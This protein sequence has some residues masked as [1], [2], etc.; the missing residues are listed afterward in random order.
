[1]TRGHWHGKQATRN[2]WY[3]PLEEQEAVDMAVVYTLNRPDLF[4]NTIGA[5]DLLPKTLDAASHFRPQPQ[6]ELDAKMAA[7]L[8]TPM[9]E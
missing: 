8:T 2:T 7:L 3:E 4:L 1:V 5:P 9:F 6:A